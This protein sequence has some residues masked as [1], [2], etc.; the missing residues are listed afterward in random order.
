MPISIR[1][2]ALV[3]LC[4]QCL[5][6]SLC[7]SG[8]VAA[9]DWPQFR[10]PG[11]RATSSG[12][13]PLNWDDAR[14]LHWKVDLP[15]AGTSS[16]V[17]LGDHLYVTCYSG[18]GV[19][20]AGAGL[21][22]A[23]KRHLVSIDPTT[24]S[25]RWTREIAAVQPEDRFE[26]YIAEHGYASNSP[27]VDAERVYA[28]FGKSGVHAF[29]HSGKPLWQ[30]PVGKESSSRKW[31]SAASLVLHSEFVIVNASEESQSVRALDRATGK[32]VWKA[33]GSVLELAYGTPAL[34]P[35]SAERTDLVLG[36]PGEVWGLNPKT[37]K[38]TWFAEHSL[39]GNISPSV[40][41]D[42]ERL[43]L[44]GGFRSAGSLS[45]KP[46]GKG[47][48]TKSS[49][50]WTSRDSS[51]VATPVLT[52]NH[53]Y[54]IDDRGLAYCLDAQTGKQVYRQR[55]AE[56]TSGGRPV[57]ASPVVVKDRIL[58]V[59]RQNGTL[60]LPAKPMYQVLAQ[61]R[62]ASDESDFNATPAIAGDRLFLRSNRRLYCVGE[63]A[64]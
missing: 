38:L 25:I 36:A 64:K 46:G 3:N 32:E 17:I 11:G 61:N 63:A 14:N 57:Y 48:A 21:L 1:L 59:T 24:G 47:D 41:V 37:G 9:D 39:T 56:I 26:G 4:F 62:F 40:I 31:G 20:D 44:F 10:G 29:D 27:V 60:V 55:V 35:V 51:Y 42:T 6:L 2:T 34:V 18:Y 28:F 52:G 45:I 15:G 43:Y 50:G 53:L 16:P 33:T 13:I 30:T 12:S 58:V 23:L 19:P 54:W 7:L 5:S 49:V 22:E 8:P